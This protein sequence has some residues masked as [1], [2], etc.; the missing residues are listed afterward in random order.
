MFNK[1]RFLLPVLLV[2]FTVQQAEAA[3]LRVSEGSDT[4]GGTII[5]D[6]SA[7]ASS[8][9]GSSSGS[10][11]LMSAMG[12]TDA[13]LSNDLAT[14]HFLVS[15]TDADNLSVAGNLLVLRVTGTVEDP[16]PGLNCAF[17]DDVRV[18]GS[19][20]HNAAG[21]TQNVLFAFDIVGS[22][23]GMP[24]G[25]TPA[26]LSSPYLISPLNTVADFQLTQA[27]I[28]F[29]ISRLSGFG[30]DEV[31]IGLGA[32]SAG[33]TATG[34]FDNVGTNVDVVPEPVTTLLFGAAACGFALRRRTLRRQ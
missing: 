34:A 4:G 8:S 10:T 20:S 19:L 31:W 3:F 6:G 28:N 2:C 11:T 30:V 18:G 14:L 29:I 13:T 22:L 12:L 32:S 1:L 23:S 21:N 26:G 5:F 24:W 15:L 9:N 25:T 16:C 17:I 33:I 27:Q 7:D